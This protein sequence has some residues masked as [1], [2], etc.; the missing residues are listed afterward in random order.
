M[1]ILV[2]SLIATA[3]CGCGQ[4]KAPEPSPHAPL[5]SLS[6]Y[7]VVPAGDGGVYFTDS[8]NGLWYSRGA[9]AVRVQWNFDELREPLDIIPSAGSG[10]YLLR[11]TDVQP[12]LL[13]AS[14]GIAHVVTE[15]PS[16]EKL[17]SAQGT[18]HYVLGAYMRDRQRRIEE[19]KLMEEQRLEGESSQD[20]NQ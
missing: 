19:E 10:V 11:S 7:D 20:S 8:Y 6:L 2:I 18:W 1:R 13:Y 14:G 17:D 12:Q 9:T 5:D 3:V 4:D 16:P 15:V